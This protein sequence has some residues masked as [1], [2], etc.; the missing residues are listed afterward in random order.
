MDIFHICSLSVF[1]IL[2]KVLPNNAFGNN[3]GDNRGWYEGAVL[4]PV[5]VVK[6]LND[7]ISKLGESKV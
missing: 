6:G 4:C 5:E 7:R 1:C 2:S 3:K